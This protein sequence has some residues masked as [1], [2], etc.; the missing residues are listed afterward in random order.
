V[1]MA[2]E[3]S[4][5]ISRRNERESDINKQNKAR[6]EAEK[7]IRVHG[8]S[9]TPPKIRRYL[10]WAEQDKSF[11]PYCNKNISLAEALSGSATEYEH[12]IPKSLTQVGMKRSEIVLA[13]HTCNQEKGDRT[14]W[15][16]W[17]EGRN[18]A[19]WQ[20]V[21][22]AAIR[23]ENT[24]PKQYRKAKLLRLKDFEREVLTDDSVNGFADRQ[25]HQTSWIAKEAAQWLEHLCPNKVSVSRGELTAM[26]RR[27]WKLETVIP[28]VRYENNLPVLD[29]GGKLDEKGKPLPAQAIS[30]EDFSRLKK[31]LEGHPVRREDRDANPS[32]DFN[33]RPDKRLDHRHHL[34]DAITLA[35]TSR[36][37]FQQMAKNYK[38]AAEKMLP[39]NGETSEERERRMKSETRLRL[40][41]PEPPLRNVRAAALDAVRVCSI[42]IKSDRY[43][44]G[45]LFDDTAYGVAQRDGEDRLRLA[46][47]ESVADL[48]KKQGKTST[49][50]ARKTIADIISDDV[51]R[52][53]SE[54]FENRIIQGMDAGIALAQPFLHPLYDTPIRKVRCFKNYAEDAQ[55]IGFTSRHGE[56]RKYLINAGYAYL[57]LYTDASKEPCLVKIRD[58]MRNKKKPVAPNVMRIYKGDV[59]KDSKD[60]LLYRVCLFKAAGTIA[61]LPICE[62]RSF[63][64]ANEKAEKESKV[65]GTISFSPAAKRLKLVS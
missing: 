47:R 24:K 49:E 52:I 45:A 16:A 61:L 23:F 2:R 54:G 50:A 46:K 15:D 7:E 60:G 32:L 64:E 22:A 6:R 1:E 58:A 4:L 27:N 5:G 11:C 63:K 38:A 21:E 59:V 40:E 43:P 44:D 39:L 57:E 36:G 12:I 62:P 48:G 14:P 29:T 25:F 9:P 31:Y 20:S 8:Q 65:G 56:H 55:P 41:V 18:D 19:R 33:R 13:H 26:Q 3:M 51:R 17:G 53:I 34:I 42:T 10:L 35:L 37:L 28:E 30:L